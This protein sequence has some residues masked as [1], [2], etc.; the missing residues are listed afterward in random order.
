MVKDG[1]PEL[2]SGYLNGDTDEIALACT[3]YFPSCFLRCMY[4][5]ACIMSDT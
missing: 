5:T 2:L 4:Q 3:K 1:I